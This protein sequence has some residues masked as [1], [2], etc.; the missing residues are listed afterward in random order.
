MRPHSSTE[1]R[2]KCVIIHN[3]QKNNAR[4]KDGRENN[5]KALDKLLKAVYNN[6]VGV[7][8][9]G[10]FQRIV[11]KKITAILGRGRLSFFAVIIA[12][13]N[14]NYKHSKLDSF[15]PSYVIH[16]ITSPVIRG[17]KKIFLTSPK[18]YEEVTAAV[19]ITPTG[20]APISL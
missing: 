15:L 19:L 10:Y 7:I 18:Y 13:Y 2:L 14:G 17:R 12:R 1:N 5:A 3:H 9:N 4:Q 20:L 16:A 6:N 11:I 8:G